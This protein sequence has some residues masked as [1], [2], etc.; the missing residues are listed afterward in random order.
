LK[1]ASLSIGARGMAQICQQLENLGTTQSM[2]GASE[3][4]TQLDR[5]FDLVKSEIERE[6]KVSKLN[7]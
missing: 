5:E 1:G 4:L 6:I 3:E 2:E 7:C